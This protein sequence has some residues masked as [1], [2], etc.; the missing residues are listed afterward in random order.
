MQ[1]LLA[2]GTRESEIGHGQIYVFGQDRV[3][4]VFQLPRRAS[5]RELHFWQDRLICLDSKNELTFFSLERKKLVNSFSASGL[6]TALEVDSCLD[7]LLVGLQNGE[8]A[9]YDMERRGNAPLRLPCFWTKQ[10]PRS[11]LLPVVSL[12]LHPRDVGTLLIGYADGAVIYS[13]KQNKPVKFFQYNLPKFAPG[14]ESDPALTQLA[15]SPK[16]THALW[17]PT[18]TFILT[19]H[20]DSSLVIWDPWDGRMIAARTLEDTQVDKPLP[21][22]KRAAKSARS[23][24]REPI[25]GV[26]WCANQDADDTG[27]LIA[28]GMP[29]DLPTKG[30]T[31]WELGRTPNYSTSSWDVLARHFESPKHQTVL[32]TPSNA[33][34]IDLCLL[35]RSSPHLAGAYEPVAVM[36][37][38]GSGEL[39]TLSFPSGYMISPTNHLHPSM[40]LVHPFATYASLSEVDRIRWLGLKERAAQG[41]PLAKGGAGGVYARKRFESRSVAL[42]AHADGTVKIWDVGHDDEIE[43]KSMIQVDVAGTLGRYDSVNINQ[44]SLAGATAELGVGL[45]SGEVIIYRWGVNKRS[46]MNAPPPP[47]A[48]DSLPPRRLTNITELCHP[49]VREGL[50][51]LTLLSMQS[52]V[53]ALK[54]SDVGF[55]AAGFED[56]S[57]FVIDLR[58]PAIIYESNISDLAGSESRGSIRKHTRHHSGR[59]Q[60]GPNWPTCLEFSVGLDPKNTTTSPPTNPSAQVMT[61]EGEGIRLSFAPQ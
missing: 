39:L 2:V 56:G 60:K 6:V 14:G 30:L 9:V 43:N 11:R 35:P 28:G 45:Q 22:I 3:S 51:P 40:S 34:V 26:K 25:S 46:D 41:P 61:L 36:A 15:R 49:S 58:G 7:F 52:P 59:Q 44:L 48:P 20:E 27:I 55:V 8:V 38:L 50:L 33:Q 54:V 16:L 32:P 10:N 13:F 24:R 21:G 23:S 53:T 42:V 29:A 19:C 12:A 37:L 4:V 17:H 1:S 18:G 5:V 31:F 47:P 57:L